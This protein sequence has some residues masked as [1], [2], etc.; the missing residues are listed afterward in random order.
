EDFPNLGQACSAGSGGCQR[1]GVFK[2][3][4][5]GTG[6]ECSATPGQPKPEGLGNGNSCIDGIDNDCDGLVDVADAACQEPEKCDGIDNDGDG[7][8]DNGFPGLGTSCTVGVGA[9]QR[10]GTIV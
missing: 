4:A 10:T 5:A 8:V 6:T 2:C 9:A 1:N 7:V 3:N